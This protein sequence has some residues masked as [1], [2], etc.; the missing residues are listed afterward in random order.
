MTLAVFA[1]AIAGINE[2]L[3]ASTQLFIAERDGKISL[4]L[5]IDGP[6]TYSR[7][8]LLRTQPVD[9][10]IAPAE[11]V[12]GV[13]VVSA[14]IHIDPNRTSKLESMG[15]MIQARF[16]NFVVALIPIDKIELVAELSDVREINVA[17]KLKLNTD[18]S[19]SY[20]N[21]DDVLNFSNDAITAG[22]PQAFKGSGV[23]VGVIDDGIDFQHTMFKDANGNYSIDRTSIT[24][25]QAQSTNGVNVT[26]T[27]NPTVAGNSNASVTISGGGAESQTVT[28]SG[29]AV[30]PTITAMP[31][32]LSFNCTEGETVTQTFTVSGVNLTGNLTLALNDPNGVYT[33]SCTSVTANQAANGV[34]VTVTYHPTAAGTHSGTVTISGGGAQPVTVNLNGNAAQIQRT[35]TASTDVVNMSTIAGETATATFTVTGQNLTGALT[36][37]LNDAN[38]V[39]SIQPSTISAAEAAQGV[40]VTVTYNPAAFG[41][42]TAS[43]VISGGGA[44]P[45][46]VNL[47]GTANIIKYA[48]VMLEPNDAYV[49]LTRF[50]AEWTDETPTYNVQS[51]TLEVNA[52]PTEPELPDYVEVGNAD[53]S[54]LTA[55]T[56]TS[57][58]YTNQINNAANYLPT[59][60]SATTYL[61]ID[62]GAVVSRA[63]NSNYATIVSP[64]YDFTGYDKVT[65]VVNVLRFNADSYTEAIVRIASS[66]GSQQITFS[67]TSDYTTF[68]V[69][70][71]V[72]QSDL[73]TLTTLQSCYALHDITIYAG[74]LTAAQ[75]LL[76]A[77]ETGGADYRLIEGIDPGTFYYTVRDLTAGG[78]FLYRVKALYIDGTESDWSNIEEVTL[79]ENDHPY[80]IGD[81]NHDE[82]VD[83][84]DVTMLIGYILG[85]DNGCCV[86]CADVNPDGEIDVADVT[87][88]INVIL[89]AP[90]KLNVPT[91]RIY[92]LLD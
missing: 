57:G 10:I 87:S 35:I 64:T 17:R 63:Y 32:S 9:R 68:T 12:N 79:H 2:K 15:V 4:D 62:D 65:V 3:S 38:G 53:F 92:M 69:V 48:P 56:N 6:K 90:A 42:H 51:Y 49:A 31:T 16:D 86:I 37:A 5:K 20:T 54:N 41:N 52:K 58:S 14:F 34:T 67:N 88:L 22:L 45:V 8:P 74:D 24:A 82:M 47:N 75:N 25:A 76:M 43:V 91:N 55:V 81:V 7:P 30:A 73:I 89:T 18:M 27:Y 46:T 83:V 11:R 23:V 77:S 26:V 78:T 19:R 36:L 60:W 59:G 13:D 1:T 44:S 33:I 61:Y 39:Y 21:T 40:T 72:A 66:M 71:D 29:T 84:N 85:V 28:L 50:R 80:M 70:L